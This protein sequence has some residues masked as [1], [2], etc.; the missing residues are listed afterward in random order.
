MAK[1]LDEIVQDKKEPGVIKS[2]LKEMGEHPISTTV[3]CTIPLAH[4]FILGNGLYQAIPTDIHA[5]GTFYS[6]ITSLVACQSIFNFE[7][8]DA[9]GLIL[10]YGA[11]QLIMLGIGLGLG[12]G[13]RKLVGLF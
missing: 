6:Y 10:P 3:M 4:G 2:I 11:S 8:E 1:G 13:V 12:Y 7:G 9:A 5:V